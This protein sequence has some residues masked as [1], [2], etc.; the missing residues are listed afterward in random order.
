LIVALINFIVLII[1]FLIMGYLYILSIQPMK[2]EEK[3]GIKAWKECRMFRSIGGIFEFISVLNLVL[4]IWFPLPIISE[5]KV[6]PNFWVGIIIGAFIMVPCLIILGKGI[7]DAGTETLSPLKDTVMYGGIY[8][9]IRHPQTLGEFPLFVAISF[10][11]NSWFLIIIS[12]ISIFGYIPIMM[13]YEE[14]DLIRRFG[15]LYKEY[16]EHM[17]AFFPKSRKNRNQHNF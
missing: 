5:W 9:Y 3:R 1:S 6:N 17:G 7:L 13:Y 2:R 8:N 16:R 10:M 14:K 11:L 12:A 4:W 15:N